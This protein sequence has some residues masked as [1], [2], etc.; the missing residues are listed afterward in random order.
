L[1]CYLVDNVNIKLKK[2]DGLTTIV[3]LSSV[4]ALT[5]LTVDCCHNIDNYSRRLFTLHKKINF[6]F[7]YEEEAT[8]RP[9]AVQR[10]GRR[11]IQFWNWLG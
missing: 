3:S 4:P 9:S 5:H 11:A 10:A 2:C 1:L 7:E 6:V 8:A